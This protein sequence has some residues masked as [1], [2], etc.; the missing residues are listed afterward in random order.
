MKIASLPPLWII[1][2]IVG[3]PQLSETV[4]TP[5]LPEISRDLNVSHS[6][7]E[8]TLTIYLAAFAIGTLFWGWLSDRLGRKK[9]IL[10]V[11]VLFVF[12]LS[13]GLVVV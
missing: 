1:C 3:L 7:V 12:V 13:K 2:L 9:C 10:Y 8:Y 11:M 6:Y 5:S 4:Y